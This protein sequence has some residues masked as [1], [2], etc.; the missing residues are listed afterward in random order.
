[1]NKSSKAAVALFV[2]TVIWGWTFVWMK[3]A[4]N[5]ALGT[6]ETPSKYVEDGGTMTVVSLFITLRFGIA[7]ILMPLLIPNVRKELKSVEVW[8]GGGILAILVLGGF[9][10]Q[11]HALEEI[12]PAVSAFLTSLYVIFTAII[13]SILNKKMISKPLAFGVIL[14]TFGAGYMQGPPQIEF[15]KAEWFTVMC[16]LIFGFHIVA[17]DRITKIMSPLGVTMTSI[18][19]AALGGG[20]IFIY[21]YSTEKTIIDL[22]FV[23]GMPF[24]VPLLL[25]SI[26]G[27]L[28]ALGLVNYFQKDLNPVRAAILFALEPVWAT[29]ISIMYGM[30]EITLWLFLGGGAL[31]LGNVISEIN[32][33]KNIKNK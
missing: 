17:T 9:L 21:S 30:T 14:A 31:L 3:E 16:A 13:V 19:I 8:K 10:F 2:V 27:T 29:L 33:E 1:M 23:Y 6:E 22:N 24:L 7:A 4:L 15:G 28:L 11:M 5:F 12:D 25:C 32:T 20:L 26:L 18:S